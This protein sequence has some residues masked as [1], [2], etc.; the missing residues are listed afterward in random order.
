MRHR[1]SIVL[2]TLALAACHGER[3]TTADDR[4][5]LAPVVVQAGVPPRPCSDSMRYFAGT[6]IEDRE[7]WY[8]AHLA[9]MGEQP[10]CAERAA[11]ETWRLTWMPSF[12]ASVVVRI[13]R[14]EGP[15]SATYRMVAKTETGAGGYAPGTLARGVARTLAVAEQREFVRRLLAADFWR[16]PT[17]PPPDGVIGVDGAQWVLEASVDGQYHVVDRW[18]P[19]R[20]GPD[21][22]FRD[23][24]EWMLE[25]SGLA[26][27]EVVREY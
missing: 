25:V 2:T 14:V 21:A 22:R 3:S 17:V 19:Q 4:I 12:H 11:A 7:P 18:T 9:T 24:A 20:D 27:S 5:G 15:D 6:A 26:A 13:E 1:C 10:L 16:T 8:G 23:L